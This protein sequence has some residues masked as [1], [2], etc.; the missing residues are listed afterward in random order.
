[1]LIFICNFFFTGVVRPPTAGTKERPGYSLSADFLKSRAA[2]FETPQTKE[3]V[4]KNK[5]SSKVKNEPKV[6]S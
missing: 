4:P 6:S 1:M 5:F 2:M 3:Y